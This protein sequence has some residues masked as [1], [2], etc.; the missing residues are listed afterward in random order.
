MFWSSGRK[1]LPARGWVV[2]FGLLLLTA[3]KT[4]TILLP[5]FVGGR[6]GEGQIKQRR[7]EGRK[8]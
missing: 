4:G 1:H 3:E 7:A 2:D 6:K 8:K 5:P